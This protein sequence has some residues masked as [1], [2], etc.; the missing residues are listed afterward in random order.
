MKIIFFLLLLPFFALPHPA[1]ADFLDTARYAACLTA[2][3]LRTAWQQYVAAPAE[4]AAVS[5]E[6]LGNPW[7]EIYPDGEQIYARNP[8]DLQAFHGRLYLGGGNSSNKGPA[9]NAGPVPVL[10][11][12]PASGQV[13]REGQVDEEQIDSYRV[14]ENQL[15]IPGHDPT[16]SWKMGNYYRRE[17]GGQ[18]RKFRNIPEALHTY[19]LTWHHGR[20][21]AGL[22]TK[23]GAAVAVSAD[24]GESWQ[25]QQLGRNRVY[26]FLAA[27]ST[28]YAVKG[29]PTTYQ[30]R[31]AK[32]QNGEDL[33]GMAELRPPG[34]FVPRPDLTEAVLF[35]DLGLEE[36]MKKIVRPTAVGSSLL[37]IG[38]Y[39][40]NDHQF[41]PFG[42]FLG[43]SFKE[44]RIAVQRICLPLQYRPWDILVHEGFV[45]LLVEQVGHW[46]QTVVR[47]LRAPKGKLSD[48][49]E[50]LH[51]AAPTFAR[52]F[53]ILQGNFY[54]GLGS[55]IIREKNWQQGELK[56]ETGAIIRVRKVM[57]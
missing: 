12:D 5:P 49:K 52:S 40:H 41:L 54:F 46:G 18:W 26:T 34:T 6:N 39:V 2:A 7:A 45:Y 56:P 50:Y 4:E 3:T 32:A 37:Y 36:R 38:A 16:E 43:T 21:F 51:F 22:G 10:A 27:D 53:E 57:P 33:Y 17:E 1:R 19:D 44:N 55:E 42:L 15:Y 9:Q 24:G 25:V 20:M 29:I 23:K 48:W 8:W 35:P 13:V 14:F 31:K 28:L 11:L 47:V 30:I